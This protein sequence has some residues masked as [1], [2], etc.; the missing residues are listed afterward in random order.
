MTM[1]T[2]E[3]AA[4][5]AVGIGGPG[6]E[7]VDWQRDQL[8]GNEAVGRIGGAEG[9]HPKALDHQVLALGATQLAEPCDE[10]IEAGFADL[11]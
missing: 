8:R 3:V 7:H 2:E 11:A 9:V 5:A 1:G 4:I 6:D 10:Q